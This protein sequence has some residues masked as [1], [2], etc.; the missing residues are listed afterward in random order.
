MEESISV[1][2]IGDGSGDDESTALAKGNGTDGMISILKALEIEKSLTTDPVVVALRYFP[3]TSGSFA[4]FPDDLE[5][6]LAAYL[7]GRG[8]DQLYTHQRAAYDLAK[9][10]KS[11]V[12]T[13]PTA[14]GKTLC[15]NL[16]ILD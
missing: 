5:P 6:K 12:V 9:A 14:S 8:L 16:P 11:F 15:Y 1:N 7:R 2:T 13:T 3:A 10:G 4:A